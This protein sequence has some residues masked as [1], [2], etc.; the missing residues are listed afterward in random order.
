[1]T[2][3][4][5][6]HGLAL[7]RSAGWN[8]TWRDWTVLL[9][10]NPGGAYVAMDENGTIVGT[11]TTMRY[12]DHFSWISMLLVDPARQR[13][14]IGLQLLRESL[15]ILSEEDTVKLDA[16]QAGRAVYV[17]LNFVD[18][19]QVSRM[20]HR[21]LPV[22][23]LPDSSAR[24]IRAKDMP[25][26]LAI[27]RDI[28]GADRRS[29]LEWMLDGAPQFAFLMEDAKEV[30][31]YCFG[32]A[33]HNFTHIGPIVS[34]H[35]DGAQQLLSSALRNC[36]G[37][38]VIVDTLH[39]TPEWNDWLSSLGFELQRPFIRMFRGSNAHP[40]SPKD[41]FAILGPEFG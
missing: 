31:A 27:D 11:V 7:C 36:E 26:V 5:I 22:S 16:T 33:G 17:Q 39:H 30:T 25:S 3:E 29:V 1:M 8:Q 35:P 2:P 28:F 23:R 19:Y 6:P 38:P 13:Q 24:P 40:G 37:K 15:R 4:D 12:G 9:Q 41:Q 20:Q 10:N 18:E 21:D 34:R 32:R 14:G